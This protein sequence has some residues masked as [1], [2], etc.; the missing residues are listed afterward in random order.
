[1]QTSP[2]LNRVLCL[3]VMILSFYN[4]HGQTE[5]K[6]DI[7]FKI[8]G[9]EMK[10]DVTAIG[11]STITFNYA[12]EKLVYTIRKAEIDKIT[13]ASGRVQSF[14]KP[15]TTAQPSAPVAPQDV[16]VPSEDRR[17]KVAILPFSYIKDGQSVAPEVSEE[18]QNECYAMLSK[19]AGI[20]S[21]VSPRA[22]NVQLNK[23]GI[24]RANVLNYTMAEICQKLGVE[25]VVD[26]MIT[27][28]RTTQTSYGNTT[29]SSKTKDND[30]A[31]DKKTSGTESSYSTNV[32]NYQTVMDM[33]IYND[34]SEI[35]YNQ[36]RKAFWN[37]EDA[38]KNTMEYLIKRCPLYAK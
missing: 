23:A 20:Y 15:A 32:Q 1:M 19:H 6:H 13:F 31:K 34:K 11:D 12:G 26:G 10:G 9:E 21:I 22:I 7:V 37:S 27:Q 14:G 29:Y 38:Y 8:N 18:I 4:V 33:K 17:N 16:A 28:N 25:Y 5:K 2:M 36:N 35:I 3:L 24:T 30:K